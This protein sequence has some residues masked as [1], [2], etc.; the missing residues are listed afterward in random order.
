MSD[1]EPILNE[2][3]QAFDDAEMPPEDELLDP[4]KLEMFAGS[5]YTERLRD[6]FAGKAWQKIDVESYDLMLVND[7]RALTDRAL[8]YYL[9]AILT[10]CLEALTPDSD[11]VYDTLAIFE[12]WWDSLYEKGVDP[13]YQ[14]TPTASAT[15]WPICYIAIRQSTRAT[16]LKQ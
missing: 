5:I 7:L 14:P 1:V 9:P 12:P 10:N 8:A 13:D 3:H 6:C 11:F 15:C 16:M 4:E 2:I